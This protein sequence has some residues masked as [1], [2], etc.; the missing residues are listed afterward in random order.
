[1]IY[2][3]IKKRGELEER[4]ETELV[5]IGETIKGDGEEDL[6]EMVD[7]DPEWFG[8]ICPPG[9]AFV[10]NA[11]GSGRTQDAGSRPREIEAHVLF[12]E[13]CM[14]VMGPKSLEDDHQS[15]AKRITRRIADLFLDELAKHPVLAP[16]AEVVESRGG[17]RDD[18]GLARQEETERDILW[19]HRLRIEFAV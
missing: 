14:P 16:A 10:V 3:S 18:M 7:R 13:P 11:R 4:I 2:M 12:F 19:V 1:M 9:G 17:S 15:R 6:Q 5:A 8:G